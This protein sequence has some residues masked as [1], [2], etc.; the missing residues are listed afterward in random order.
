MLFF[1]TPY[2]VQV[3]ASPNEYEESQIGRFRREVFRENVIQECK[4][5]MFFETNQ[6]KRK[7]KVRDAA[8]R[9]A[10]RRKQCEYVPSI[11]DVPT[12]M[13]STDNSLTALANLKVY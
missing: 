2:N 13:L 4:R 7:R 11:E 9:R 8:R 10:R 3:I 5:R 6:E 12:E 1:K